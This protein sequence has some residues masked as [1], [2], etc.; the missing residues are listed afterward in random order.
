M[1]R[2]LGLAC[3]LLSAAACGD[4][5]GV[6]APDAPHNPDASTNGPD[7]ALNGDGPSSK[8]DARPAIPDGVQCG[9]MTCAVGMACCLREVGPTVMP[10]CQDATAECQP[11]L[12]YT[13]DGPEDCGDGDC[14]ETT[15]GSSCMPART[16]AGAR[17]CSS[18]DDCGTGEMCC[19]PPGPST[20]FTYD[21]CIVTPGCPG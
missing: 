6:S 5:T 18:A 3:L 8:P 2:L 10:T 17:L 7:A 4:E 19:P 16:C 12:L 1:R 15:A 14:C 11:G 20:L 21:R 9:E 13:C